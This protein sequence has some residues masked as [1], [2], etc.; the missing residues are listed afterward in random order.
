MARRALLVLCLGLMTLILASCGQTYELQSISISPDTGYNL[1]GVGKSGQLTITAHY[2]NSKT[3]DVTTKSTFQISGSLDPR[4]PLGAVAV[5]ESG[6]V[7]NSAN[8]GVCTWYAEPSASGATNTSFGY[9][10]NPYTVTVTY[11]GHTA[12]APVSVDSV[13]DCYDGT[14]YL[15]P[16]GYPGTGSDGF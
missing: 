5:N 12:Q 13:A 11:S 3:A 16:A 15:P 6:L 2:S 7:Q 1:E 8:I 14:T 9:F 10:T 4:A